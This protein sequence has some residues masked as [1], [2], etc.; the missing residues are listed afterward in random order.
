MAYVVCFSRCPSDAEWEGGEGMCLIFNYAELSWQAL[1]QGY[2]LINRKTRL[3]NLEICSCTFL[4]A[5][6][7]K[8]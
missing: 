8:R 4:P 2:R 1:L 5:A 7:G 3:Q 6:W